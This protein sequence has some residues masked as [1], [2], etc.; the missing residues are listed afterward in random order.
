M[1]PDPKETKRREKDARARHWQKM[2]DSARASGLKFIP[3]A[4]NPYLYDSDFEE[5][6]A[7]ERTEHGKAEA[8]AERERRTA[9]GGGAWFG[10]AMGLR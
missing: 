2:M 6:V 5:L 4:E 1:K 7:R 10:V 9:A 8:R 3:P